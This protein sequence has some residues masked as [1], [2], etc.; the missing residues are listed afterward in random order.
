MSQLRYS[1][2]RVSQ[3]RYSIERDEANENGMRLASLASSGCIVVWLLQCGLGL[4]GVTFVL[5]FNARVWRQPSAFEGSDEVKAIRHFYINE[6]GFSAFLDDGVDHVEIL[7]GEARRGLVVDQSA[8]LAEKIHDFVGLSPGFVG[9]VLAGGVEFE[10]LNDGATD[11]VSEP[12]GVVQDA[13][14]S[15]GEFDFGHFAVRQFVV[16]EVLA[17]ALHGLADF[18]V[19]EAEEFAFVALDALA[20]SVVP[21][22][23]VALVDVPG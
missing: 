4:S 16:H 21:P 13:D 3:L 19:D 23:V 8:L 2:E 17:F 10:L 22:V 15:V 7:V 1:I 11:V 6:K 12:C 14:K 18:G 9:V 5:V 20:F